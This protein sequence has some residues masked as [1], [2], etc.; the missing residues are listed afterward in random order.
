MSRLRLIA[1]ICF[2]VSAWVALPPS[3]HALQFNENQPRNSNFTINGN[4]YLADGNQPAAHVMVQ[5]QDS[6]GVAGQ[7][8]ETT[9]SGW[10]EFRRLTPG[11]YALAI[12]AQGYERVNLAVDLSNMAAKGLVICLKADVRRQEVRGGCLHLG[13]RTFDARKGARAD[14][15][16]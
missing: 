13:A 2:F 6:E 3:L 10:F 5:L 16:R 4:V 11:T 14:E 9:D 8:Q 12:D 1:V 15:C 7:T